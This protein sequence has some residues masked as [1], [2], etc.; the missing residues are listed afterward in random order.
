MNNNVT[1]LYVC[2]RD[3]GI[4]GLIIGPMYIALFF[5]IIYKF[6]IKKKSIRT[7]AL[8]FYL[9]SN[10]PYFLFEFFLNRTPVILTFIYIIIMYKILY[11]KSENE[12][13]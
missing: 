10:L 7:D 3:F 13:E 9:A 6:Y 12:T 4:C 2:L 11:Y 1:F 8:Y 5:A